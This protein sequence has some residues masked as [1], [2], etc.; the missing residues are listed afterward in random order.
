ME[1]LLFARGPLLSLAVV[2]FVLGCLWRLVGMWRLPAA[3]RLSPPRA[4]RPAFGRLTTLARHMLPRRGLWDTPSLV[5]INP[6]VFHLGLAVIAFGYRPH[7]AFIER[8]LGL[9][10]PALPDTVIYVTAGLT[11]ASLLLALFMRLVNRTLR[12]ISGPDDYASWTI[13]LLIVMTGMAVSAFPTMLAASGT[14]RYPLVLGL[15]LLAFELMLLW[16]PFGKLFHA[17]SWVVGRA[18][19]GAFAA[20]R[21]VRG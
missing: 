2:I 15:H 13:V 3:K 10:W 16:F 4:D 9:H 8:Y 18:Q 5:T 21:G 14:S 17:L 1:T 20:R 19:W 6:Y 12:R 11:I 7:I